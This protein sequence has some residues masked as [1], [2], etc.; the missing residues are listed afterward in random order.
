M[1]FKAIR[2][3]LALWIQC[4]QETC[5][6]LYLYVYRRFYRYALLNAIFKREEE[7]G[8]VLKFF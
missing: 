6:F 3:F 1:D 4:S 5:F 7:K 2:F 8:N